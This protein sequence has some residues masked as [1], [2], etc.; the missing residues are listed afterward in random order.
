MVLERLAAPL[1][2][3]STRARGQGLCQ[4]L[5]CIA[6]DRHRHVQTDLVQANKLLAW[7]C[8]LLGLPL[9]QRWP[10]P[11]P[12]L[13]DERDRDTI[14]A[15]KKLEAQE[16]REV[17]W[18]VSGGATDGVVRWVSISGRRIYRKIAEGL[19]PVRSIGTVV[20]IT[21]LKETEAALHDSERRLRLALEAARM[22]TFEVDITATEAHIDEQEARLLGLPQGTRIVPV[23]ELRKRIPLEDLHASDAKQ[24]RMTKQREA[25]HHEFRLRMPDG[26]E[27]W[28]TAYADVKSNRIFGVNFDITRRKL[29]EEDSRRAKNGFALQPARRRWGYLNGSGHRYRF[30]GK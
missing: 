3:A 24:E 14:Q 5:C 17:D 9:G 11:R 26:S 10:T 21:H 6:V 16:T 15:T 25:Y 7:L 13:I 27:R 19:R 28:L 22:G 8:D 23:E 18:R 4:E 29:A 20:D 12:R 1:Q 2:R 30:L